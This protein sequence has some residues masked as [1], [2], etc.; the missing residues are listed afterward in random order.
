MRSRHAR[1]LATMAVALA[2]AAPQRAAAQDT[3]MWDAFIGTYYRMCLNKEFRADYMTA[4][5][6]GE[7]WKEMPQTQVDQALAS[8]EWRGKARAWVVNMPTE[9]PQ[10]IGMA[11]STAK[12]EVPHTELCGAFFP[13]LDGDYFIRA[14]EDDASAKQLRGHKVADGSIAID[15]SLPDLPEASVRVMYF[16]GQPSKGVLATSLFWGSR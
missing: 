2:V 12:D 4:L 9:A 15:M 11:G 5:A 16:K 3:Q 6:A 8:V 14:L 10:F 1:W 7:K 13:N